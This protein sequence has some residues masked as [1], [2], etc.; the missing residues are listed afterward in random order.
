MDIIQKITEELPVMSRSYD[1]KEGTLQIAY[2]NYN[3]VSI[4]RDGKP[5]EIKVFESSKEAVD[6][7]VEQMQTLQELYG[8]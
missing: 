8:E 1:T 3:K 7:Y 2:L 6:F 4:Q 5:A